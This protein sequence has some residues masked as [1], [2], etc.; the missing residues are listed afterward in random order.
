V[1]PPQA[2]GFVIFSV[3]AFFAIMVAIP[4]CTL[5]EAFSYQGCLETEQE[6]AHKV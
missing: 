3:V 6:S 5:L 1:I 4:S 2:G